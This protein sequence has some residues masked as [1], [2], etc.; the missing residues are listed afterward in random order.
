MSA[1]MCLDCDRV[2]W[3]AT[4]DAKARGWANLFWDA[5]NDLW[6]CP[7]CQEPEPPK[8]RTRR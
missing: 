7:W 5:F 8:R 3:M 6:C 1:K 2:T 4:A